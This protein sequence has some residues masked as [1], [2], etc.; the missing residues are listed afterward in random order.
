MPVTLVPVA[1]VVG[2]GHAT[3]VTCYFAA[4][5]TVVP[6]RPFSPLPELPFV[7]LALRHPRPALTLAMPHLATPETLGVDVL[8]FRTVCSPVAGPFAHE[9]SVLL[10]RLVF[11]MLHFDAVRT[12]VLGVHALD[13]FLG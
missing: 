13:C 12:H 3:L 2:P 9:A 6:F 10:F 8:V 5:P 1:L 4:V 7:V 11:R